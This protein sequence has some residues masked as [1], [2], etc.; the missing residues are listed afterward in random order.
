MGEPYFAW[1]VRLQHLGL[2]DLGDIEFAGLRRS[3]E[4]HDIAVQCALIAHQGEH[5]MA[6]SQL[7]VSDG[8]RR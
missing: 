8:L 7:V 1:A 5:I 2:A 3:Q 6:V 4:Q